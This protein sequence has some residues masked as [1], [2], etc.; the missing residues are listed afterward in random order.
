MNDKKINSQEYRQKKPRLVVIS[1]IPFAQYHGLEIIVS[2][3]PFT[4]SFVKS[5]NVLSR[6]VAICMTVEALREHLSVS[7]FS[8]EKLELVK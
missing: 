4:N 3:Q 5:E 8:L 6:S 2:F 1:T 7:W